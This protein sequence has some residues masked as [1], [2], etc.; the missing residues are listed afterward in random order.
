[1]GPSIEHIISF[2]PKEEQGRTPPE[3]TQNLI[4]SLIKMRGELYAKVRAVMVDSRSKELMLK[5]AL[6]HVRSDLIS[7]QAVA[8]QKEK[9]V[10]ALMAEL[11]KIKSQSIG[12]Q[13]QKVELLQKMLAHSKMENTKVLAELSEF[14]RTS[15]GSQSAEMSILQSQMHDLKEN[16]DRLFRQTEEL[17]KANRQLM[18]RLNEGQGHRGRASTAS[19]ELKQKHEATLRL[20]LNS[21]KETEDLKKQIE[22]LNFREFE[23]NK[24]LKTLK[25]KLNSAPSSSGAAPGGGK[26][27]A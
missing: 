8:E 5:K 23:L 25:N 24:E 16:Y 20:Y 15:R 14:R 11:T 4:K 17:K 26:K 1:V 9:E 7:A 21:K 27:S 2:I 12:K 19:E 3:W 22:L 10:T 6:I 18:I 13:D